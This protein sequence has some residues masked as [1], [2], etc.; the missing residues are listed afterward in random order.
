MALGGGGGQGVNYGN[1]APGKF[2]NPTEFLRLAYRTLNII[3][4]RVKNLDA[5]YTVVEGLLKEGNAQ[6]AARNKG[7][8]RTAIEWAG[9]AGTKAVSTVAQMAI[10][11]LSSIYNFVTLDFSGGIKQGLVAGATY[12]GIPRALDYYN[13][14]ILGYAVRAIRGFWADTAKTSTKMAINAVV[15]EGLPIIAQAGQEVV[16][17]Q[18]NSFK[19]STSQQVNELAQNIPLI[20]S[21]FTPSQGSQA[22]LTTAERAALGLGAG[23][24]INSGSYTFSETQA[25]NINSNEP[26]QESDLAALLTLAA[27]VGLLYIASS[28]FTA[29][30]NAR[31]ENAAAKIEEK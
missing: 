29:F 7:D 10:S 25:P 3:N 13:V 16:S 21:L 18:W 24:T 8:P 9:Y 1:D 19:G 20:G 27:G 11:P 22:P 28:R 31:E 2:A 5:K 6:R 26:K 4:Q 14:P 23:T 30:W 17:E 15:Y 12:I